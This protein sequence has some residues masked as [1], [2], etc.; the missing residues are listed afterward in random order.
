MLSKVGERKEVGKEGE[1]EREVEGG[2]ERRREGEIP[3]ALGNAR[4]M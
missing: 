4:G 2:K 3:S 1:G